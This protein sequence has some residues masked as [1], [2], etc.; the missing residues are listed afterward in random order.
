M[1]TESLEIIESTV[2]KRLI[3]EH[4]LTAKKALEVWDRYVSEHDVSETDSI[5]S[6][7][8]ALSNKANT[9]F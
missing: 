2:V 4:G 9:P 7:L 8:E 6:I 1:K 5:E 3:Q